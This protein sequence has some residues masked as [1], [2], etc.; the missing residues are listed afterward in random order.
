MNAQ[1]VAGLFA[2]FDII[3]TVGRDELIEAG[4]LID[5]TD[6]ARR[7]GYRTPAAI[8]AAVKAELDRVAGR[9]GAGSWENLIDAL[10]IVT[11]SVFMVRSCAGTQDMRADFHFVGIAVYASY[12]G[13]GVTILLEGED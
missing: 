7:H 5:V 3:H 13:D 8:T 10:L 4:D 2:G 11:R 1:Q 12:D 6:A 9:F